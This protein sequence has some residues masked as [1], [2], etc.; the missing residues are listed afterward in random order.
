VAGSEAVLVHA[1]VASGPDIKKIIAA[2]I[3]LSLDGKIDTLVH[4][5][6]HGDDSFLEEITEEF[7]TMQSDINLKGAELS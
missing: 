4:N 1:N 6:G 7:Y 5:A 2:A 3:T